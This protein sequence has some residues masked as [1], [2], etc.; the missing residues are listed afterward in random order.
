MKNTKK[1]IR[2]SCDFENKTA[3]VRI[4]KYRNYQWSGGQTFELKQDC[5]RLKELGD[6]VMKYRDEKSENKIW[7][8]R[9]IIWNNVD[10]VAV[11]YNVDMSGKGNERL[12]D[13][14]Y[15]LGSD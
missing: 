9:S 2:I 4:F 8:N 7:S 12:H 15:Y 1:E 6:I 11:G 3:L 5:D 13:S 10:F 14:E